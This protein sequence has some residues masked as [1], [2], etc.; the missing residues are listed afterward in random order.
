MDKTRQ[1][2]VDKAH[3]LMQEYLISSQT[4]QD[5]RTRWLAK[6]YKQA[7]QQLDNY[8]E[9]NKRREEFDKAMATTTG[10][11]QYTVTTS[12]TTDHIE[13]ADSV[14][15]TPPT[16]VY[17]EIWSKEKIEELHQQGVY[18]KLPKTEALK[19]QMTEFPNDKEKDMGNGFAVYEVVFVQGPTKTQEEEGVGA[20]IVSGNVPILVV[21][22]SEKAAIAAA[23]QQLDES[24][25][26][27]S[28]LI[29]AYT[30]VFA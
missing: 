30:R 26:L 25:D 21:A 15:T 6:M 1:Q 8:D 13:F 20:K 22:S 27:N 28:S 18:K 12:T 9:W 5:H 24:V 14:G 23:G 2:L 16:Y 4:T 19:K 17:P 11:G 7:Q 29:T 3:R 10:T